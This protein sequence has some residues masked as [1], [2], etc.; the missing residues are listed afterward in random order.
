M[1][2]T[3]M[4]LPFKLANVLLRVDDHA[5]RHP[6]LYFRAGRDAATFDASPT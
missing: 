4:A 5:A 1:E 2:M 3:R 6:E